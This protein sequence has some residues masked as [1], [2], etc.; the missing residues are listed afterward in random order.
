VDNMNAAI[1]HLSNELKMDIREFTVA[2]I[3]HENLFAH[4]WFIGTDNPISAS[5]VKMLLDEKLKEL[6]TDYKIKR[7]VTLK[8][9]F[10]EILPSEIFYK[11][12][13][14]LGKEGGQNKFPRV[15][16]GEKLEQWQ[17]FVEKERV[18]YHKEIMIA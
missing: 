14:S 5:K 15:I 12:H 16:K 18:H 4:K 8:K 2:G 11:Y 3:P 6:N 10:V 7:S 1:K 17:N 9:I 13:K